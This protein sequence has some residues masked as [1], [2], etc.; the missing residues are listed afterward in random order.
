MATKTDKKIDKNEKLESKIQEINTT[1]LN[2]EIIQKTLS[3]ETKLL[4]DVAEGYY[5]E[6]DK[7][8]KKAPAESITRLQLD[9]INSLIIDT[10]NL[11]TNDRYIEKINK[12]EPAGSLPENRDV[13]FLLRNLKQGLERFNKYLSTEFSKIRLTSLELKAILECIEPC[14]IKNYVIKIETIKDFKSVKLLG[15]GTTPFYEFIDNFKDTWLYWYSNA[16]TDV[17]GYSLNID[18]IYETDFNEYINSTELKAFN[19]VG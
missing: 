14:V 9:E 17:T 11:I 19:N 12:F 2:L 13:L 10:K 5:V 8:C 3:K 15:Y 1:I 4:M 7:L 18:K 6:M 16:K